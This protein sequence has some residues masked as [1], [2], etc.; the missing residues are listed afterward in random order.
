MFEYIYNNSIAYSAMKSQLNT[1]SRN[2]QNKILDFENKSSNIYRRSV[3]AQLK[4][5]PG[6]VTH[7]S[8]VPALGRDEGRRINIQNY[9]KIKER[10]QNPVW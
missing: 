6:M 7:A 10:Q 8:V 9:E 1:S 2:F 3:S 5:H 4:K